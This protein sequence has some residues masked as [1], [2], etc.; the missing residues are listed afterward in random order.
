M[1]LP[2]ILPVSSLHSKLATATLP[3][4]V[5]VISFETVESPLLR[6]I[7]LPSIAETV[8]ITETVF[9]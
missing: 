4:P 5:N 6:W 9:K 1:L 2:L 8:E 7:L 3:V